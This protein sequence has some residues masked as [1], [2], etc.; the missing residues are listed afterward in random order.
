MHAMRTMK[1]DVRC[2]SPSFDRICHQLVKHRV[3]RSVP[4]PARTEVVAEAACDQYVAE[5]RDALHCA[6]KDERAAEGLRDE[7]VVGEPVMVMGPMS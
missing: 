3:R 6:A 7:V 2:Q 5:H 1:Q 4:R